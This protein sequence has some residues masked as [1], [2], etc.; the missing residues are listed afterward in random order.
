MSDPSIS[1]ALAEAIAIAPS[2]EVILNAIEI[3][4]PLFVDEE[5]NPDSIWAVLNNENI[6][7]LIEADAPIRGGEMVEHIGMQFSLSLARI[8]PGAVQEIQFAIDNVDRR[9][10]ENLDIAI[11]DGN[12]IVLVFR[13]F[14]ST[15]LEDGPQLI[16]TYELSDVKVD[17][18]RVTARARTSND[19]RRAFP[20]RTYT[21]TEF[22]ALVGR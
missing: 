17:A 3:R 6:T 5:G 2:D 4:H 12:R 22:P 9:I 10:V 14:L 11:T 7:A 16:R 20:N 15:D 13:A 21:A 8:Q 1:E 19:L 18:M